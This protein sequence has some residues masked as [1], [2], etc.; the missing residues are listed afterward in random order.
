MWA[1]HLLNGTGIGEILDVAKQKLSMIE[2]YEN[3]MYSD[4]EGL[5]AIVCLVSTIGL[6]AL[7]SSVLVHQFI[8]RRMVTLIAVNLSRS[9]LVIDS[10]SKPVLSEAALGLLWEK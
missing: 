5:T 9:A 10:I 4:A 3:C 2:E 7:P 8:S 1:I 6:L